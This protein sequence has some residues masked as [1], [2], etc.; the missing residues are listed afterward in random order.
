MVKV[1]PFDKGKSRPKVHF[2]QCRKCHRLNY[3][4]RECNF[5]IS[6]YQ[7]DKGDVF[8]KKKEYQ[9]ILIKSNVQQQ[10]KNSAKGQTLNGNEN[11]NDIK[12]QRKGPIEKR[13]KERSKAAK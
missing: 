4:T 12:N 6:W 9:V 2:K 10:A 3:I 7:I 11:N 13:I 1:E 8:L 5:K